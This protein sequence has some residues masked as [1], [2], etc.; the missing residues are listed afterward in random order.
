MRH[1]KYITI[2]LLPLNFMVCFGSFPLDLPE[3]T[4]L[5]LPEVICYP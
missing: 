2:G 1:W 3:V 4:K 5:E